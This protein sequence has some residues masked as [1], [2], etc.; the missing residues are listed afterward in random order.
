MFTAGRIGFIIFFVVAFAAVLIWAYRR[1]IAV[2]KVHFRKSY[3]VLLALLGFILLM[4]V[5]VKIRKY[6]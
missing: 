6:M 2:H 3:K 4:F 5:L 1:D